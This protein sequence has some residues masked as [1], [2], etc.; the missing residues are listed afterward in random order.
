MFD[1]IWICL[2]EVPNMSYILQKKIANTFREQIMKKG[3]N[4]VSVSS[5]M[6]ILDIRRQTFY[7]SFQDKY[8]LLEWQLNDTLEETIDNNID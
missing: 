4:H 6:R 8:D 1:F 2:D 5:L 7:D 3:F